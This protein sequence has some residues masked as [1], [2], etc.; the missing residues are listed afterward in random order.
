MVE[1]RAVL[2]LSGGDAGEEDKKS[3]KKGLNKS[4]LYS[5]HINNNSSNAFLLVEIV[6]MIL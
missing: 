6:Y 2:T 3:I 4:S 1:H 5:L